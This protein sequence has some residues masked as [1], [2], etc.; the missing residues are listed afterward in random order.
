[1]CGLLSFIGNNK[2]NICAIYYSCDMCNT[3]ELKYILYLKG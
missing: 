1:M 2:N 3:S